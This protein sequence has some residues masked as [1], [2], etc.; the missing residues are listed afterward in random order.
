[1]AHIQEKKSLQ[2]IKFGTD[3]WR[4]I[5]ADDYTFANVRRVATAIAA[6][7][8]K[9]EHPEKG[10]VIGYDT[11]F[12]SRRF[13]EATAEV[14]ASHGIHVWLADDYSPTP[15]VSFA[16]KHK[17]A[18]GGVVITSSHNPWDWNGVKY[19]AYYGGSAS[20]SIMK[21]I[22][23]ELAAGMVPPKQHAK[24]EA[25]DLKTEY[26]AALK[27][28]V[29]V[30]K[31]KASGFKFAIDC[32]YGAGRGFIRGIFEEAGVPC[33]EIR[34]DVNPLFPGINPEPI[35]PHVQMLLD[36][37]VREK[38][39]AGIVTDGDA[40]RIGACD[41]NGNYV[42][43]HYIFCVLMRWL[44]ER[45]KWPGII[46]RAYNTT[47]MI[48]RIAAK[49]GRELVE[50]GIGFK[51]ACDIMLQREVL[52]GGEESGGIGIPRHLPERDGIL[53]GL[54]IANVMADE[55]KTLG[56]LVE[57]LQQEYG[58]HSYARLDMH[59]DDATKNSA[60][61]RAAKG[62][63]KFGSFKV[64]SSGNLDGIKFYLETPS[65]P[66]D[67]EAWL[68]LRASGTEHMLRVYA[69]AASPDLVQ[70]II[71]AAEAFVLAK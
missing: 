50:H 27:K 32:M 49:H 41:E 58:R 33:V 28:F 19:K 48:D 6:H 29:D 10:V 20:P 34:S 37:T 67:A 70:Q 16:V 26:V 60:I 12:G 42:T 8:H 24:I 15:A 22:E 45:K 2:E 31:I 66:K 17:G 11:R 25:A 40:D 53:N 38:C 30:P 63:E 51:Y 21:G 71:K 35:M 46:T 18:S 64:K 59:I 5:I 65:D 55:N 7:I 61:E 4:G 62:V 54:L 23:V 43:S 56:Q 1:M 39:A 14:I 52:I 3:G 57:S 69:E 9:N 68:L 47:K 13:A 44:L 36:T